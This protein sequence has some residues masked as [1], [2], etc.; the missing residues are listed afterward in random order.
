MRTIREQLHVEEEQPETCT[1]RLLQ[2]ESHFLVAPLS[3][4]GKTSLSEASISVTLNTL[5]KTLA[6]VT[7]RGDIIRLSDAS[8]SGEYV[9]TSIDRHA[10]SLKYIGQI[11]FDLQL[12]CCFRGVDIVLSHSTAGYSPVVG[13][14][15]DYCFGHR[16]VHSARPR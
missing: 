11:L 14:I 3:F 1:I 9:M 12:K 15:S 8:L 16:R 2:R 7:L 13:L 6:F 4:A 5:P 10:V